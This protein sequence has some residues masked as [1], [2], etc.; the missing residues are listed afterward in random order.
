[1]SAAALPLLQALQTYV[2]SLATAQGFWAEHFGLRPSAA[3]AAYTAPAAGGG[4]VSWSLLP[5]GAP[6]GTRGPHGALP[7]FQVADFGQA[8]GYLL[9]HEIPIVFEEILPG[10]SLLIFLDPDANPIELAQP[11]DPAAWD[12][13]ERR[14]L[15]TKGRRD[16]APAA[17]LGL[18]PL[19]EVT[20]Y[21]HDITNS[22]RFYRDL[23]G[24]PVG[25][26]Y[27]G[28]VHLV[29]ENAP[30]VLR[31]VNWRCKTPGA[32]HSTELVIAIPPA[33]GGI[34]A[35]AARFFAAGYPPHSG[36]DGRLVVVDPAGW[37]VHFVADARPSPPSSRRDA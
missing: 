21:T 24:L 4:E 33:G 23:V 3:T 13:A 7:S 17:P 31:G 26:S 12:I 27:F 9:A 32:L 5:G 18:G 6:C 8:R 37:R 10:M 20:V 1:M 19:D 28:H 11:T 36:E 16:R 14:L 35:L 15:R 2:R 22:V 34:E 30:L 25:L 29:L